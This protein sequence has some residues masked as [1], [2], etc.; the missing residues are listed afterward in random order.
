MRYLPTLE[1]YDDEAERFLKK[2]WKKRDL[3]RERRWLGELH[4][5]DLVKGKV[6]PLAIQWIDD[7]LGFGVF[8]SKNF[9][10]F[11]NKI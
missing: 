11:C 10:F 8:A 3:D 6:A 4:G 5:P 9:S 2:C 7:Q 1:I